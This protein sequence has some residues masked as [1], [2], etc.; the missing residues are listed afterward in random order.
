MRLWRI[1]PI[2]PDKYMSKDHKLK[3]NRKKLLRNRNNQQN[4]IHNLMRNENN[5]MSDV[6]NLMSKTNNPMR[7]L[8][9]YISNLKK[10]KGALTEPYCLTLLVERQA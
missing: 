5:P 9:N 7:N 8:N 6:N 4:S 2:I 10:M 3:N 1:N